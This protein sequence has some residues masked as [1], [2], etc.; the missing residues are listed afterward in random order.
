MIVPLRIRKIVTDLLFAYTVY[1]MVAGAISTVKTTPLFPTTLPAATV[2]FERFLRY[3]AGGFVLGLGSVA[4]GAV[5]GF[6]FISMPCL[7]VLLVSSWIGVHALPLLV[8]MHLLNDKALTAVKY[9]FL[10]VVLI[11]AVGGP[12]FGV[13]RFLPTNLTADIDD[14]YARMGRVW[15]DVSGL[16]ELAFLIVWSPHLRRR[17]TERSEDIAKLRQKWVDPWMAEES[18]IQKRN[19]QLIQEGFDAWRNGTGGVFDL[20]NGQ[21]PAAL[22]CRGGSQAVRSFWT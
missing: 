13:I 12:L 16:A 4:L 6:F 7:A 17:L 18:N 8:R 10:C 15:Y 5:T 19:K 21:L 11:L 3:S 9:S 20:R 14:D 22:Q 2:A 1:G